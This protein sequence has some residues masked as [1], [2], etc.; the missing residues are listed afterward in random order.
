MESFVYTALPARVVF[1]QGCRTTI[2]DEVERLGCKR[3]AVIATKNPYWN[4]RA[5][6]RDD[7]L[8]LL[9][10]AYAGKRPRG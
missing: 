4:P 9:Q 10:A 1:R 7:I 3:A 2:G 6:S 5:F 8:G